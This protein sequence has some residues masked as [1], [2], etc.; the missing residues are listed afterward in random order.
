LGRDAVDAAASGARLVS[1]GEMN[2]VS[3]LRRARRTALFLPSPKAAADLSAEASAKADRVR[4]S[5]VVLAPVAG[6]KSA[7]V[8]ASPTGR[9][10]TV[11][12]PM[13]VTKTNS[14]PGRARNK[15]LRPLRRECRVF[16][17]TCGD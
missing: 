7:E 10:K 6:V 5:R 4:Q 13:T 9:A 2:L 3:D 12:S 17:G 14:S 16:R 8:L 15:P 11:N 1:Q